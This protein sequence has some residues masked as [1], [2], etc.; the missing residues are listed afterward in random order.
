MPLLSDPRTRHLNTAPI[1]PKARYVLYWMQIY[2]RSS[3][4]FALNKAIDLANELQLPLV[5]YEGLKYSYPWASDRLHTFILEGVAEKRPAFERMG[6]RYIFFLENDKSSPKKVFK[7][8]AKD[9]AIVVVED[10]PC[11]IIPLHNAAVAALEIPVIA[12]DAN[13]MVPMSLLPKEEFAAR[14]I[15]PKI[16]RLMPQLSTE[17]ITPKLIVSAKHL[18]LDCVETEVTTALIPALVAA[19]TIDHSVKPSEIYHG[20]EANAKKRLQH[21]VAEILPNYDTLR[22]KSEVDGSS[23]L[24]AW[25]HFGF[26]SAQE[27]FQAV[28]E[29]HAPQVAKDAYLEELVIRR[30]LS[31]N[32]TLHNAQYF[33]LDSLPDWAKKTM[34]LHDRDERP[35]RYTAE[36]IELGETADILWNAAQHELLKTGALHNYMRMLWGKRIMEWLPS[37][38]EAFELMVHLNNKYALDGRDPNSYAG[39]LWCF[40]KHDRAWGPERPVYGTLRYLSS[41]RWWAKVGAKEYI[42]QY[43]GLDVTKQRA[44]W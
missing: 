33:S 38:E 22:N 26:I 18:E 42:R 13:G 5:V 29:A 4:N 28:V 44:L 41:A 3:H 37:Y 11:F 34:A 35:K 2:K 31:F 14:T 24:S 15:R 27:I 21:F 40:G 9:A 8:L 25:L 43:S 23:R 6:I 19:C 10:Y 32:F 20:G 39:I 36:Q 30:E 17:I 7:N 12:V 1:N 16:H